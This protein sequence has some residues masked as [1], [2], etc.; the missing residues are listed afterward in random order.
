MREKQGEKQRERERERGEREGERER[1]K[2][3]TKYK[4]TCLKPLFLNC[5]SDL[6]QGSEPVFYSLKPSDL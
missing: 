6:G 4:T 3:L 1:E 5:L 2:Q